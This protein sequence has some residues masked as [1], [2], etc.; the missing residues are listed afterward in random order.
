M[1][2]SRIK[3]YDPARSVILWGIPIIAV[4]GSMFHFIY[5]WSGRFAVAGIIAPVNESVWEHLKMAFFPMLLFWFLWY[6]LYDR[7]NKISFKKWLISGVCAILVCKLFIV[8]FF[9]TYTGAFGFES[10]FLDI[11]SLWLGI[12]IG[13]LAGLHI[14]RYAKATRPG[15]ILALV[16]LLLCLAAFIVFTFNPPHLPMFLDMSTRRYGI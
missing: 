4:I 8:S 11:L 13:Q 7:K 5:E 6:L 3:A 15:I 9:Y 1:G 12:A 2:S 16:A 14:Y 10:L